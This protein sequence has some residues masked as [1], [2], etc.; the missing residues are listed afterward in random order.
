MSTKSTLSYPLKK[1]M[2]KKFS[3][4]F[5]YRLKLL[6]LLFLIH[7]YSRGRKAVQINMYL[8]VDTIN[9]TLYTS[10]KEVLQVTDAVIIYL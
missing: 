1:E 3:K 8:L 9:V 5:K 2:T 6:S 4:T 7:A 10:T